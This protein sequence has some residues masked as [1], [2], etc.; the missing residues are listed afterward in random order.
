[1]RRAFSR[2]SAIWSSSARTAIS[3]SV[4]HVREV[5]ADGLAPRPRR[6]TGGPMVTIDE[7]SLPLSMSDFDDSPILLANHFL[8]QHQPDEF[9][10]SL[11]QV[12]APP[13]VGPPEEMAISTSTIG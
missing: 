6:L 12:T 9:V 4:G 2:M 11:S 5:T 1:M 10:V 8:I 3:V 13:L 7:L